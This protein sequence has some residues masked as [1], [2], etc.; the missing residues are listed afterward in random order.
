MTDTERIIAEIAKNRVTRT[1]DGRIE[2]N[3]GC[4]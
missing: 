1:N 3:G 2:E 4:G